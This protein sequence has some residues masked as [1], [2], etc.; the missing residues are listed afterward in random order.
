VNCIGALFWLQLKP[1]IANVDGLYEHA[2]G[3][4]GCIPS[5]K[6]YTVLTVTCARERMRIRD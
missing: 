4:V 6:E 2:L 1:C 5:L 3:F